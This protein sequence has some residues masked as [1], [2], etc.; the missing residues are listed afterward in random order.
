MQSAAG[1]RTSSPTNARSDTMCQAYKQHTVMNVWSNSQIVG[2]QGRIIS[3]SGI[4][5][6]NEVRYEGKYR[7][8]LEDIILGNKSP[9]DVIETQ[10]AI[11]HKKNTK[12][13][14]SKLFLYRECPVHDENSTVDCNSRRRRS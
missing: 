2:S 9:V 3:S 13:S 14:F 6:L 8:N 4:F 7:P 12:W 1:S 5:V 10:Q 11:V